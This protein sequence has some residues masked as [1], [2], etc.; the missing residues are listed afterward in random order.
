MTNYTVLMIAPTMPGLGLVPDEVM[1]V[2]NIL[3][4]H[5]L[6]GSRANIHGILDILAHE[7]DVVWFAT[8]GNEQG[9]QLADGLLQTSEITAL[10]RSAGVQLTV[11]NTCSSEEIARAMYAEL[12]TN[13]V[14]TLRDVPDRTAYITGV[15]FAR[16]LARGLGFGEAYA[17][18]KPGQNSTYLFLGDNEPSMSSN[19]RPRRVEDELATIKAGLLRIESIVSGNPQWNVYGLVPKARD[20]EVELRDLRNKVEQLIADVLIM[21]A[22]QLFNRRLVIGVSLICAALLVM[23]VMLLVQTGGL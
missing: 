10:M 20:L 15:M 21:R 23:M 11:L 5:L 19:E 16:G 14:A 3:D 1:Q 17:A 2:V 8:H 12:G 13:F 22:N 9:I 4:A 18:A 6:Q 7:W